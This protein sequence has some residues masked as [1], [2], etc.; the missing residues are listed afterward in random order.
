[1]SR[2]DALNAMRLAEY[3]QNFAEH[4]AAI[5]IVWPRKFVQ[6]V[7]RKSTSVQDNQGIQ[8]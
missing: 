2:E 5:S 8:P 6:I 1:M 3:L 4:V 7:A